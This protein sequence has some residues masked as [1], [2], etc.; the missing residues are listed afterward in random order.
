[1]SARL[2]SL[3]HGGGWCSYD[4]NNKQW[5]QID[6]KGPYVISGVKVQGDKKNRRVSTYRVATS[7]DAVT[8]IVQNKV[9][10]LFV[11]SKLLNNKE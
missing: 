3:T 6:L 1:M 5:L 2:G 8:W 10:C 7:K 4:T 11:F 9:Q